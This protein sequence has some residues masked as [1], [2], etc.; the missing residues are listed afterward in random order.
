[1]TLFSTGTQVFVDSYAVRV[2]RIA[3][4]RGRIRVPEAL[5]PSDDLGVS[6]IWTSSA[7]WVIAY[8]TRPFRLRQA[9]ALQPVTLRERFYWPPWL[10][11][12][13]IR[14]SARKTVGASSLEARDRCGVRLSIR[15]ADS[16]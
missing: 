13:Q 3:I 10:L 4:Q 1:M 11:N 2:V 12:C 7:S 16:K 5:T 15:G 14:G 8:D 9:A 6:S